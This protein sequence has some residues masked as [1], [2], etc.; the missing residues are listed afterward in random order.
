MIIK[1][2]QMKNTIVFLGAGASAAD[3]API[4][5][6]IF[7]KIAQSFQDNDYIRI[8]GHNPFSQEAIAP[9]F[10]NMFGIDVYKDDL[11]KVI[12]PTAEEAIGILD[13]AYSDRKGFGSFSY[14]LGNRPENYP[15]IDQMRM[16]LLESISTAINQ[17]ITQTNSIHEKLTKNLKAKS[18]LDNVVFITTN[19]DRLIDTALINTLGAGVI[20][21]CTVHE[22]GDSQIKDIPGKVSLLKLHGSLDWKLCP[23]CHTISITD[24]RQCV[25]CKDFT[26]IFIVPPTFY[27]DMGYLALR[28]VWYMFEQYLRHKIKIKP[29]ILNQDNMGYQ[30][31]I[32]QAH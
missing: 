26:Q 21:Y 31:P 9:F 11:N 29:P 3:G 25:R 19:Y 15:S 10:R 16:I 7:K 12:F 28:S 14:K 22:G 23:S 32:F 24:D 30:Q 4:Q 2:N 13:L 18:L 1:K 27:K 17:N 8:G 5:G 6:A 20:N